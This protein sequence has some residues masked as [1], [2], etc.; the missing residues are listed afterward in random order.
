MKFLAIISAFCAGSLA[1]HGILQEDG[2]IL[3]IK[4]TELI[5]R[6]VAN[7]KTCCE[8]NFIPPCNCP[9]Y[10]QCATCGYECCK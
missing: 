9:R 5:P 2:T 6:Q 1:L 3:A 7:A 4:D 8:T 10:D